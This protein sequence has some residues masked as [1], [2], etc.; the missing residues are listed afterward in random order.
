MIS[1]A[2]YMV[3]VLLMLSAAGCVVIK[4]DGAG[5]DWQEEQRSNRE[6]ISGLQIGMSQEEV[7]QR[8]GTPADS[9]ALS[10]DGEEIRVLFYRTHWRK[11]D[12]ETTRDETTPL[13]FRGGELVGWGESV[14]MSAR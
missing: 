3:V 6:T 7:R 4:T 12:G 1:L 11:S 10:R 14:Y 8:L 2:Q 13:V 5:D 9:E